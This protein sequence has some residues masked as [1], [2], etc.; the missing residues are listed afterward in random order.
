MAVEEKSVSSVEMLTAK[1]IWGETKRYQLTDGILK[2][3]VPKLSF[4]NPLFVAVKYA[5]GCE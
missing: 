3:T 2:F 1:G 4:D 5:G